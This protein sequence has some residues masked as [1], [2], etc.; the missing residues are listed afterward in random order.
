MN[1]TDLTFEILDQESPYRKIQHKQFFPNGYGVS[2]IRGKGTYGYE[3]G[4]YEGAVLGGNIG[5]SELVYDTPVTCDV[6]GYLSED[7]VMKFIDDVM[8]LPLRTAP[9]LSLKDGLNIINEEKKT[10]NN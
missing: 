6:E 2:I 1:F 10:S 8:A 4:L 3:K 5:K 9:V 7:D